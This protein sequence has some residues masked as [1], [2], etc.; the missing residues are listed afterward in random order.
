[1]EFYPRDWL[2]FGFVPSGVSCSMPWRCFVFFFGLVVLGFAYGVCWHLG[3]GFRFFGAVGFMLA[4][5]PV[6]P[7]FF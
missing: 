3:V 4:F 1:M 5:L 6:F 2:G 7:R